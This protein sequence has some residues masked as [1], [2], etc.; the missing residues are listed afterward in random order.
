MPD[1]NMRLK[2]IIHDAKL[3]CRYKLGQATENFSAE[4]EKLNTL[5]EKIKLTFR[6]F[7]EPETWAEPIAFDEVYLLRQIIWLNSAP[8]DDLDAFSDAMDT[9]LTT[10]R[11]LHTP[12]SRNIFAEGGTS[13]VNLL[14]LNQIRLTR[15][16]IEPK[17]TGFKAGGLEPEQ[18]ENL[19]DANG[20]YQ[21]L[22][23]RYRDALV[24]NETSAKKTDVI[25][26][27][28]FDEAFSRSEEV[29]EFTEL[30]REYNDNIEKRCPEPVP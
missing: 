20:S 25:L 8:E 11:E 4:E 23:T 13:T 6:R 7:D 30:L 24:S 9:F 29:E 28:R 18:E 27:K 17:V 15:Q 3:A 19:D 14:M 1:P 21:T 16:T 22:F 26:F 2:A 5:R 12:R 10:F